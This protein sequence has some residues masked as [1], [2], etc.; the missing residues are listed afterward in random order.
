M[1]SHLVSGT[2]TTVSLKDDGFVLA[3]AYLKWSYVTLIDSNIYV[4]ITSLSISIRCIFSLIH[5]N[6]ASEHN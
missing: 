6:A 4:S 1:S 3:S 5:Y 2:S